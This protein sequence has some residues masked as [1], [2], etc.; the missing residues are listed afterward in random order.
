MFGFDY[1]E[2]FDRLLDYY[3]S[4]CPGSIMPLFLLYLERSGNNG[5]PKVYIEEMMS[6]PLDWKD[7]PEGKYTSQILS[8]FTRDDAEELAKTD[9]AGRY[10]LERWVCNEMDHMAIVVTCEDRRAQEIRAEFQKMDEA[11][12]ETML[13]R[14]ALFSFVQG[15]ASIPNDVL[16]ENFLDFANKILLRANV[17][18]EMEDYDLSMFEKMAFGLEGSN[19][20]GNVFVAQAQAPFLAATFD[21]ANIITETAGTD[22]ELDSMV[23][24][25]LLKGNGC[26]NVTCTYVDKP[27]VAGDGEKYDLVIMNRAKHDADTRLSDWHE[28]LKNVMD[29]MSDTCRFIGLVENKQLFAHLHRQPVFRECVDRKELDMIILLPKK[30]GCSVVALNKAKKNEDVVKL[31]NLYNENID[32]DTTYEWRR[33]KYRKIIRSNSTRTTI[34]SLQKAGYRIRKFFEYRL[35]EI[36]GFE[37]VPL[38]TFLMRITPASTFGVNMIPQDELVSVIDRKEDQPYNQFQYVVQSK[39]VNTFSIYHSY[40]YL[41][42]D[43]LLVSCKGDLNPLLYRGFRDPAYVKDV[44]AFTIKA[45][46]YPPYIINELGKSYVKTQLEHW[47]SS[48][49]GYHSEEQILDLKIYV[50]VCDDPF[51]EEQRI[52]E[53]ELSS[54]V[55][56]NGFPV[57]DNEGGDTYR[58]KKCLGQ[59]GFG[60]SYLAEIDNDWAEEG[61]EVVLK[62][63]V[64]RGF[65]GQESV[66]DEN[67]RVSLTFGSLEDVTSESNTFVYLVKFI[68]EGQV[69]RA[70]RKYRGSRIRSASEV[71]MNSRTNTCYYVMDYFPKGTLEDELHERGELSEEEAIERIMIPLARALKT[72]HDNRWVHLDVKAANVM[73]DQDGYAVLGDLGIS[74]HWDEEGRKLTKG[75]AGVGGEGSS[76]RQRDYMDEQFA[77]EFHPEQDVYSMAALYY[78]IITG[79]TEHQN[80]CESDLMFCDISEESRA[81]II[82]GL[83]GGDT[84]E[85]TPKS[86]LEFM[87][88]LPGCQDLE[89]PEIFPSEEE[90]QDADDDFEF[91][92]DELDLP[93]FDLNDLP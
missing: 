80:F 39:Y 51:A 25:L 50:P 28:C 3:Y 79:N 9:S 83:T 71:F 26:E 21:K 44:L 34:E 40:Y 67:Y 42:D 7:D 72:M 82:A 4:E 23:S 78:R 92:L 38:R 22:A 24:Y 47:T 52:T 18:D 89:L 8:Q 61:Q 90:E 75:V 59:G 93:D 76:E 54:Y 27:F 81:A 48:S 86:V 68:E 45:G 36:E 84:L 64:A 17:L 91:D 43:T 58:I 13:K 49:E 1:N 65:R 56:P 55:L 11:L 66:R 29:N 32:F 77:S 20:Q 19:V 73:I 35:P 57:R 2:A 15:L 70:F 12:G 53:N 63:Y 41:D 30:Y 14:K 62:E 16:A 85:S 10:M 60:I 6:N 31:V 88:M 69:M 5:A 74:Q 87:R 37:L 33:S 46:I